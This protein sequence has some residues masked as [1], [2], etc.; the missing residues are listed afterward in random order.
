MTFNLLVVINISWLFDEIPREGVRDNS[1]PFGRPSLSHEAET[2]EGAPPCPREEKEVW[3]REGQRE[4]L[5][6]LWG[7]LVSFVQST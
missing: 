6:F 4:T 3:E 1:I 7:F 5:I 2:S